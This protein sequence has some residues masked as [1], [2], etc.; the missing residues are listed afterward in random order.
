MKKAK[1]VPG[2]IR[3]DWE[4]GR[5]PAVTSNSAPSR[6]RSTGSAM[7]F[8]SHRRAA[9]SDVDMA[10]GPADSDSSVMGGLTSDVDDGEEK[11]DAQESKETVREAREKV[12]RF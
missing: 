12:S 6:S 5:T 3:L 7:S 4:R 8:M 2:G 10:G 9:S 1:Q 11:V